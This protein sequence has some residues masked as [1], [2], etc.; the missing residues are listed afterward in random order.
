MEVKLE[1]QLSGI[2]NKPLFQVFIYVRKA[3]D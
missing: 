3:Y 2:V 1:Q